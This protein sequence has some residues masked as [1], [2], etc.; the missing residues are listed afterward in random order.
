MAQRRIVVDGDVIV[1]ARIED[2][3]V[4]FDD[5]ALAKGRSQEVTVFPY[6]DVIAVE[7]LIDHTRAEDDLDV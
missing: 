6:L 7:S 3:A 5:R 2:G 4:V 1:E